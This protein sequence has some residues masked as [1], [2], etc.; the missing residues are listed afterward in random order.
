MGQ[1][2]SSYSKTSTSFSQVDDGRRGATTRF[3]TVRRSAEVAKEVLMS[4]GTTA[5]IRGTPEDVEEYSAKHGYHSLQNT[6]QC[7]RIYK[8][9]CTVLFVFFAFVTVKAQLDK[10]CPYRW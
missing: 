5:F 7:M 9:A 3:E 2:N 4:D 10:P 1:V 6:P 8:I